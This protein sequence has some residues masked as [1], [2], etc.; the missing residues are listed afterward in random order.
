[1]YTDWVVIEG[2]NVAACYNDTAI[3]HESLTAQ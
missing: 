3:G 1:M 2:L